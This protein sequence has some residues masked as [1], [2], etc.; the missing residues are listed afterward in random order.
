[1]IV[2][3]NIYM[4]LLDTTYRQNSYRL[5]KHSMHN[6]FNVF[7][8]NTNKLFFGTHLSNENKTSCLNRQEFPRKPRKLGSLN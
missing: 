7:T 4:R 6:F 3:L 8:N 5:E 2:I 1:M